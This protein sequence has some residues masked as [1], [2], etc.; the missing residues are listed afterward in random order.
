[1]GARIRYL[2]C[3]RVIFPGFLVSCSALF[4]V[5][6]GR[7]SPAVFAPRSQAKDAGV[8][9]ADGVGKGVVVEK[10]QLCH[11]VELITTSH[12]SKDDWQGIVDSMV[13]KGAPLADDEVNTVVNYLA[14]N[15]GPK[16]TASTPPVTST[17]SP[18]TASSVQGTIVDPD[19]AP[20]VRPPASMGLPPGMQIS[21][22]CG[23][24]AK[25]GLFAALLK[26]P[27]DQKIDPHWQ[28]VDLDMVVLRGTYELGRGNIYDPGKLQPVHAGEVVHFPARL[29][30]FGKAVGSTVILIYGVGPISITWD[31]K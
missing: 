27:S 31:F 24:I 30:H 19:A 16:E 11:S 14:M 21:V 6:G 29:H 20:F 13:Q 2:S 1:V 22:I 15:Y 10:C 17:E 26:L 7:L 28:S 12:R 3:F 8:R 5:A 9:I 25:A 18:T 4:A 23:D